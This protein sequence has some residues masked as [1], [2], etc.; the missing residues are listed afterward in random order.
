MVP[1]IHLIWSKFY[2]TTEKRQEEKKIFENYFKTLL[3]K[4]CNMPNFEKKILVFN[5]IPTSEISPYNITT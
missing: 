2:K 5:S 1:P 3:F 4:K